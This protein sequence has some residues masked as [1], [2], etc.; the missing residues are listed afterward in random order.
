MWF[1]IHVLQLTIPL[2][3]LV[4]FGYWGWRVTKEYNRWLGIALIIVAGY[5]LLTVILLILSNA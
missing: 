2:A 3:L 1:L 5:G 4:F